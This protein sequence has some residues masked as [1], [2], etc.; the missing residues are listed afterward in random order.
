MRQ[1]DACD[2]TISPA[3]VG[4]SDR[5]HQPSTTE[6]MPKKSFAAISSTASHRCLTRRTQSRKRF[7]FG[8]N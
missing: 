1:E 7:G 6:E 3:C 2:S 5:P 4:I 8:P